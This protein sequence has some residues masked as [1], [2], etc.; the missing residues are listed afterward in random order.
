MKVNIHF[1][2]WNDTLSGRTKPTLPDASW[3]PLTHVTIVDI[4]CLPQVL[5][6]IEDMFVKTRK[7]KSPR[8]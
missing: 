1:R 3:T 4:F 6:E 2:E 8:A 7:R 5:K